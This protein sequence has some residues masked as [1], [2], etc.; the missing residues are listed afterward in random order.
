VYFRGKYV[1]EL[2]A[3]IDEATIYVKAT[4]GLLQSPLG[5]PPAVHFWSPERMARLDK[6]VPFPTPLPDVPIPDSEVTVR[7]GQPVPFFGIYEP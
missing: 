5:E 7:T 1:D 4:A 3:S 2:T 6:E